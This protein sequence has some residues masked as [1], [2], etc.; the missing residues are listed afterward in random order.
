VVGAK[1]V[2][3]RDQR[4][5][6]PRRAQPRVDLVEAPLVEM[7]VERVDEPLRQAREQLDG[8]A[9]LPAMS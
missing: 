9:R 2:E 6:L 3:R 5:L 7:G 1:P 4:A 8:G